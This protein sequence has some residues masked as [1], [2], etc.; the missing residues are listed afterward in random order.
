MG[1]NVGSVNFRQ[2]TIYLH[3]LVVEATQHLVRNCLLQALTG[4]SNWNFSNSDRQVQ[5]M[6]K[7]RI[8]K[9]TASRSMQ[10]YILSWLSL[11]SE[12]D[13]SNMCRLSL[14][15]LYITGP[16]NDPCNYSV[17][18]A[19]YPCSWGLQKLATMCL[20]RHHCMTSIQVKTQM[21]T[22]IIPTISLWRSKGF[23]S[24][25]PGLETSW[26]AEILFHWELRNS[27]LTKVRPAATIG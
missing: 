24:F 25:H 20:L 6:T 4:V 10:S 21:H 18:L 12:P 27:K 8:C 2:I 13:P 26:Y 1:W 11:H 16:R 9:Q 19:Q 17:F 14:H 23:C 5:Q 22:K 7:H 15:H 3:L